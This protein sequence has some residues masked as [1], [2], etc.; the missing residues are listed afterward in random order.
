VRHGVALVPVR[1]L[2]PGKHT[3]TVSYLGTDTVK[4]SSTTLTVDVKKA[5]KPKKP[6]R[7]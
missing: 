5:K 7:H 2:T 4:P 6:K 1:F 3:I